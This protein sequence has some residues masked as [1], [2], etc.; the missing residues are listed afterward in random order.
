MEYLAEGDLGKLINSRR[1]PR[2]TWT[3][4]ELLDYLSQLITGFVHLQNNQGTT[5]T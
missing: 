3:E 1:S 2:Q 5:K 4:V